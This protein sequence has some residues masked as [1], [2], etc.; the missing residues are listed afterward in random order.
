MEESIKKKCNDRDCLSKGEPQPLENFGKRA[1]SKDGYNEKCKVCIRRHQQIYAQNK[2]DG[3]KDSKI[4]RNGKVGW[5]TSESIEDERLI[6]S[7]KPVYSYLKNTPVQNGVIQFDKS[8]GE[9]VQFYN[10][11]QRASMEAILCFIARTDRGYHWTQKIDLKEFVKKVIELIPNGAQKKVPH[12]IIVMEAI[13]DFNERLLA[14]ESKIDVLL[15][16]L[17]GSENEEKV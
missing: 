5:D 8:L 10:I 11:P 6:N 13:Q 1:S 14:I 2:R 4:T 17:V 16:S 12:N 9:I 15:I 7:L 3:I